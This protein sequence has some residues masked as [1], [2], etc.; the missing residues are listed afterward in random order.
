MTEFQ[1]MQH[2]KDA[3]AFALKNKGIAAFF[4]EVGCGKTL[5]ALSTFTELRKTDPTLKLLVICPLSLIYGAWVRE[6][7]KFTNYNWCDLHGDKV[8]NFGN[9]DIALINFES[10]ISPR[11]FLDLHEMLTQVP[12]WMCVIDESSKMKN[13]KAKTVQ[14]ILL[15]KRLFK[16][17]IP[18]SGTPAPNV[19]WEYWPQMFFM[20]DQILGSNFY[21]FKNTYFFLRRGTQNIPSGVIM[22]AATIRK[23]HEQGFKYEISP[24]KRVEMFKAMAPWC[25][26]VKAKDCIDL[27]E[28]IDEFRE[29]EMGPAQRKV[30]TSMEKNYLAELPPGDIF[31]IANVVLT[32]LMKLRQIT[33]GF[34]I[35]DA[36]KSQMV[37]EPNP[38]I[39]ALKEIIEECDTNEQIIIWCHFHWEIDTIFKMLTAAGH[40]VSQL[41][42]RIPESERNMH[43]EDFLQRRC[44]FLIAHPASAAHGLTLTNSHIE[45][46]FSLDCSYEGYR[47]ARGRIYRNGQKN[48]CL[49]FHLIARDSIDELCLRIIQRKDTAQGALEKYLKHA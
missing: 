7:Q 38:K 15:L 23:M 5:S 35:D 24:T 11:K 6:I 27:P 10:L 4:H 8:K 26:F 28:E 42:G 2:Q 39:E 25:H 22:N 37:I 29:I 9:L 32:K 17:R 19:E 34:A 21:K 14:Q 18:M 44:K 49:Y 45:I 47:Q 41:H 20:S 43:L 1:L 12:G 30:Y 3:V 46:F 31:I 40:R 48:N 16:Y 33:S 13:H 36:G